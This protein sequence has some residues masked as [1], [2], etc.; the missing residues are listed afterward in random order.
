MVRLS[1]VV[2]AHEKRREWA[3]QLAKQMSARIV[4]DRIEDRHETGYRCLQAVEEGATH[5]VIVQDDAIACRGVVPGM[6]RAVAQFPDRPVGMYL[7]VGRGGD[8]RKL[9]LIDTA[10]TEGATWVSMGT[11]GPIW[12][13][14]M[15]LPVGDLEP[16]AEW[17]RKTTLKNYDRRIWTWYR[18]RGA[19]AVYTVPSLFDHRNGR[20][21]PSLIPGRRGLNRKAAWFIGEDVSALDV[22]WNRRVVRP[23]PSTRKPE[24]VEVGG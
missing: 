3:T 14:A 4:W 23:S 5:H 15:C 20:E 2:M 9:R 22:H 19:E 11:G 21:N 18:D 1:V 10:R 6:A 7:G 24:L 17:Y 16:L 12:G 13:V 8:A